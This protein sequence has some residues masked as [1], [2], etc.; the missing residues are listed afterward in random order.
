MKITFVLPNIRISGGVKA[1]FEFANHLQNRGH[2]VCVT[3]PL[4]PYYSAKGGFDLRALKRGFKEGL[5]NFVKDRGLDWFDLK[6]KLIRTPSLAKRYMPN[7]DIVVATWWETAYC[8]NRYSNSKGAKFYLAQHCETWGGP[9]DKVDN[10]YKLGLRIVVNSTWLKNILEKK[11]GTKVKALILHSP[12]IDQFYS[13]ERSSKNNKIRILMA[14]RNLKWKGIENGVKAFE[15][16]REKH[17][18]IQLV[19]F[20]PHLGKEVPQYAEFHERPS[21]DELR[22]IYNSCDIF[23]FSSL[24]EGF[25]MPPME[26]ML[27]KCAVVTTNVGA[28]PDYAIPGETALVCPPGSP[29]ALSEKILELIK[30]KELLMRISEAGH[31]YIS[32]NFSWD[33][34][35]E[36]LEKTF[37]EAL[38]EVTTDSSKQ[39]H[40]K[41]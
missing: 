5:L 34:A 17:Q 37:K 27:C 36:A 6:V 3:Y 4:M 40:A 15:M 14:Y 12:D 18:D 28:V 38:G 35:S 29:Q 19:M 13:E 39:E 41:A 25:G 30:D 16:V 9:K 1:V 33:K 10:S 20:G 8:V 31:N 24:C 11:F 7:A 22:H 2:E 23:L 32:K 26:A 21:N